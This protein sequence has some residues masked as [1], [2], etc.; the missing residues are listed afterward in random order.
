MQRNWFFNK[1]EG[2]LK[3]FMIKWMSMRL[4]LYIVTE[5]PRSGGN[6]ASM[7]LS[8]YLDVPFPRRQFPKFQSSIIHGHY[9]YY[10]GMKNV[11]VMLRDG[12]DIMVSYY[13]YSLFKTKDSFNDRLVGITR[14]ELQFNDYDDIKKNLPEFIT[15][16]FTRKKHPRFTWGE[17]INSWWDKDIPFIKYEDM[18]E[19]PV[20]E[21]TNALYNVC[22]VQPDKDLLKRITEKYSFKNI[23]GRKTGEENKYSFYRKGVAGDWQNYFS[24]EA[25]QIFHRFAGRELIKAGYEVDDSWKN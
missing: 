1:M 22:K 18:L 11:F 13:Y 25:R 15:Y 16:K 9:L 17:F 19:N 10:P 3:L 2:A 4:P 24:K 23:S 21:L 5:Y 6:W 12:R 8:E 20:E 14:R 7:M